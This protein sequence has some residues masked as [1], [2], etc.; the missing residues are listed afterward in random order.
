MNNHVTK[1]SSSS[2]LMLQASNILV[3]REDSNFVASDFSNK[4]SYY[5]MCTSLIIHYIHTCLCL[6]PYKD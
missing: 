3:E 1:C 4:S 5:W 6:Y 2:S